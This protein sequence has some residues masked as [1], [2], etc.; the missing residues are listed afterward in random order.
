MTVEW[1]YQI[2]YEKENEVNADVLVLGAGLAGCYAAI[3]AARKGLK[4]ALVDKGSTIHSGAAGS[5]IDHWGSCTSNPASKVTPEEFVKTAIEVGNGSYGN[6]IASYITNRDSYEVLLELE[7]MGMK[8]RDTDDEFK[9]AP[10]RDEETKHLYAFDYENKYCVRIWGTE[11]K[12]SLY[13]E[14]KRLGVDLYERVMVTGLLT[15][16]GEQGASAMRSIEPMDS[17]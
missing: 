14:C 15:E 12:K 9:G 8:V 11:M 2:N 10:F 16:N 4:V 6:S 13:K 1:P 3:G 7:E 5:G 17:L